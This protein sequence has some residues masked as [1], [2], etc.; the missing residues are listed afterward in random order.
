MS[1]KRLWVNEAPDAITVDDFVWRR[2]SGGYSSLW[3][4]M[5]PDLIQL[6]NVPPSNRDAV[7]LATTAFLADRTIPRRT[8]WQRNIHIAVPFTTRDA[9]VSLS[10]RVEEMLAFLTSD[11]WELSITSPP[12][13]AVEPP[14]SPSGPGGLVCLFSGGSDS[15]CGAIRAFYEGHPTTLLSHWDW[16]VHAGIQTT[17]VALLNKRFKTTVPHVQINLGRMSKQIGGSPFPDEA[18]RRSRSLLFI[19]LGLAAAVSRGSTLWVPENGFTSLNPPLAPERLGALSTRT[20]H[21]MFLQELSAILTEVGAWAHF[22]SPFADMTK[23]EMFRS[24]ANMIGREAATDVLS[25]THSCS[26]ARLGGMFG[27]SPSTHCGLCLGCLVRRGAF[28]ASEIEDRTVYLASHLP[29][30]QRHKFLTTVARDDIEAARYAA[31][32]QLGPADILSMQLPDGFDLESGLDLMRR[33]LAE[34]SL[35]DLP[36]C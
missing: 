30:P 12:S 31:T 21:P 13:Q 17:L 24:I 3:T 5:T 11:S 4:N 2:P 29:E 8:G 22:S 28:I 1:T 15:M 19:T 16:S 9:W 35:I 26:H 20:T 14:L 33:G 34:I 18:S 7:W 10:T 23:G 32:S 6:G 25:P 27:M 36:R